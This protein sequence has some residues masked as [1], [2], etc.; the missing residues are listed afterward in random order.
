LTVCSGNVPISL[1]HTSFNPPLSLLSLS[2]SRRAALSLASNPNIKPAK[3][4][5]G[6]EGK[7]IEAQ[8]VVEEVF[9]PCYADTFPFRQNPNS[10]YTE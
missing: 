3:G 10:N 6:E 1:S 8:R 9:V 2:S 4:T 7:L 5:T